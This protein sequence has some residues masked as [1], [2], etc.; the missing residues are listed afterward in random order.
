MGFHASTDGSAKFYRVIVPLL[1]FVAFT[2]VFVTFR[3]NDIFTVDG[4]FRCFEVYR[5]H[6]FHFDINNHLLYLLNV[7]AWTR[8]ASW[9]GLSIET[10]LQFFSTVEIMNCLAGAGC[11]AIF[12]YFLFLV[13][14]SWRHALMGTI[15]FGLCRAFF[16]QATNANQP[17]LGI[18]WSFLAL[19]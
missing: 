12:C 10:P 1:V 8:F 7:F 19:Y 3:S 14:S 9:L 11:L 17:M 15:G 13:T 4:A 16:A 18:F 5:L 2:T 6:R